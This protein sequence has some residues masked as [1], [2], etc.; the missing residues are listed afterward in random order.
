MSFESLI[1]NKF[2]IN[3]DMPFSL[4]ALPTIAKGVVDI[5][6]ACEGKFNKC[7]IL[8]LDNTLW[9]GIIGDDGIDNIEI[10]DLGIGK[11]FTELQEWLKELKK[12]G[13][14][15]CICSKNEEILAKEPFLKHPDMV[16]SLED[17]A[18]F[19]ANWKNKADNIRFIQ[20]VLNIGF[21]S[22]VFIDDNPFE[23]NQVKLEIPELTI[24]ELP[25]DPVDYLSYLKGL[26]LFETTSYLLR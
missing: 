20:N 1:S 6:N 5:V 21:D 13:I 4:D 22:M 12:R 7:V 24:P 3:A 16:L 18:V 19:V 9:G 14:I 23:R 26:N 25:K 15:L 2:Y 10:G 17:I 11:A 8:D